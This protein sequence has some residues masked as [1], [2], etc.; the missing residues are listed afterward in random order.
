MQTAEIVSKVR[1]FVGMRVAILLLLAAHLP[2]VAV[3]FISLWQQRTHY[4]FF[5]FAVAAF[6]WLFSSRRRKSGEQWS[7]L[8][9]ALVLGDLSCVLLGVVIRSPWLFAFGMFL[10]VLAWCVASHEEGYHRRL[11]YL[12]LLPLLTI[13]LPANGDNQIIAWLQTV[14]TAVAS[15][16][17]Q[18]FGFLHF[19]E[20][21]VLEFPGK[22]FLVEEACS[23]VQ[24]LFT[25]LFIGALVIC[26]NRRTLTHG[27]IL[28]A[29]G[30]VFAGVMNVSR[31]VAIAVAWDQYAVDLSTGYQHDVLGYVCL[32]I[33]ALLLLSADSFLT[34]ITDP[35]PDLKSA[36]TLGNF[37]NPLIAAWNYLFSVSRESIR[38]GP[39]QDSS[40]HTP[41]RQSVWNI[42]A[43]LICV[44]LLLF[45]T[46]V[47][48][49]ETPNRPPAEISRGDTFDAETLPATVA[50]MSR[51]HYLVEEGSSD[52]TTARFSNVWHYTSDNLEARVSCDHPYFDWQLIQHS[53]VREGWEIT[54]SSEQDSPDGWSATMIRMRNIAENRHGFL[55]FSMFDRTGKTLEPEKSAGAG[56]RV[57]DRLFRSGPDRSGSIMSY[58]AQTFVVTGSRIPDNDVQKLIEL[59]FQTRSQ[60][61]LAATASAASN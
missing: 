23:G 35:V 1:G 55:L 43:G 46:Y 4:Q 52:T 32:G 38:T 58:L 29:S 31:V 41:G 39:A 3:Y 33:A 18:R 24:S 48:R 25:I 36:G 14:T 57:F 22:R 7:A 19:R 5:P 27:I 50:G 26:W 28:L 15:R 8:P 6:I 12:A 51:S 11:T 45:Q 49:G 10:S 47:L 30:V 37:R 21:N 60:L 17:L 53:Y 44:T 2:Y 20:G 59:H 56:S 54:E 34:F 61:R 13:R 9:V 16:M 42:G 40:K